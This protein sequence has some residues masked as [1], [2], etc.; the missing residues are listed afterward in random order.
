MADS[1]RRERVLTFMVVPLVLIA[2]AGLIG[3]TLRNSFQLEKLREQSVVEAT[4][5]VAN[6]K[7][8]RL[9]KRIIDQDNAVLSL[10]DI[11]DREDFARAWLAVSA[12]Q[13]PSVSSVMLLDLASRD[14][15]V[16]AFATRAPALE[17]EISRRLLVQVMLP[18]MEL[19]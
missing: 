5:A 13:T 10:V 2:V 1:T 12:R 17:A 8:D 18:G 16:V 7:S 15:E 9:D 14:H 3:Y 6:D 11:T 4:L 19:D